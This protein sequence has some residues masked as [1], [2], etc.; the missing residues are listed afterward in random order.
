MYRAVAIVGCWRGWGINGK[1]LCDVSQWIGLARRCH[2]HW[3][4]VTDRIGIGGRSRDRVRL[5]QYSSNDQKETFT[6]SRGVSYPVW[7]RDESD[8]G[9]LPWK[10]KQVFYHAANTLGQVSSQVGR[11]LFA[12]RSL[13]GSSGVSCKQKVVFWN[14]ERRT[15]IVRVRWKIKLW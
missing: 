2:Q 5:T 10:Q 11:R 8:K 12:T 1:G 14:D 4:T 6:L 9:G 7:L 3:H 13:D 15:W